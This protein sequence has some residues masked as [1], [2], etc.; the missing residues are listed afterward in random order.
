MIKRL[1]IAGVH[2]KVGAEL[3]KYVVR[4]IGKLDRYASR[5]VRESLHAEVKLK[6][7]KS[8]N[9]LSHICEVILH[10]PGETFTLKEPAQTIFEA[11][12]IVEQKM[13]IHFKKYK[14][15]HTDPTGHQHVIA[16]LKRQVI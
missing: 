3:K 13:K 12:D 15:L 4:K 1:E 6:A 11:I 10:L 14:D 2:L 5:H 16:R 9:K 8:K 7:S